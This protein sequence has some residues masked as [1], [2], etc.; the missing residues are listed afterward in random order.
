M[1]DLTVSPTNGLTGAV[2]TVSG[3]AAAAPGGDRF[4]VSEAGLYIL[5]VINGHSASQSVIIDDPNTVTP[6]A[7][8]AWNPDVT[9]PVLNA[10][11]RIYNLGTGARFRDA[12]GWINLT[13]SGTT[14]L[15]L[16][17]YRI[18]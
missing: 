8:T 3:Y 18:N 17:P 6:E 2:A 11:G 16:R 7:P 15:T 10:V 4:S 9:I 5:H 14:L 13:Y 12:N 1:A